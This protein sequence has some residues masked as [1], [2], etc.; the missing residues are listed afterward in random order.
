MV[1]DT[2]MDIDF[3]PSKCPIRHAYKKLSMSRYVFCTELISSSSN[4]MASLRP[5]DGGIKG[6]FKKPTT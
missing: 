2:V 4:G 5:A 1:N 6:E 3:K